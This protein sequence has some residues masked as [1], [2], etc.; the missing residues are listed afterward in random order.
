MRAFS[1]MLSLNLSQK[2]LVVFQSMIFKTNLLLTALLA[3][4]SYQKCRQEDLS[5]GFPTTTYKKKP[6]FTALRTVRILPTHCK[7]QRSKGRSI[8]K[9]LRNHITINVLLQSISCA[10]NNMLVSFKWHIGGPVYV[11]VFARN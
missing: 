9:V 7:I 3:E 4:Y 2:L 10:P 6:R 8:G 5:A 1:N 11:F